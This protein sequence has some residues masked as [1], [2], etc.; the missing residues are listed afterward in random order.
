MNGRCFYLLKTKIEIGQMNRK[1]LITM[2]QNTANMLVDY[3]EIRG[4]AEI[5]EYIGNAIA[6]NNDDVLIPILK[7]HALGAYY[8]KPEAP[9]PQLNTLQLQI[10]E[11]H[12]HGM[13]NFEISQKLGHTKEWVAINMTRIRDILN[14]ND[15]FIWLAYFFAKTQ[16]Q[17]NALPPK[18]TIGKCI[19]ENQSDL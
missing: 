3:P 16:E 18:K 19:M 2:L 17:R 10:M 12:L 13:R 5:L 4:W 14:T 11:C 15:K 9:L 7:S 1:D 6:Q 8:F